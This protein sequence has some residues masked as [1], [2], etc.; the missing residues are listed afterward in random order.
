MAQ[1]TALMSPTLG[2][3]ARTVAIAPIGDKGPPEILDSAAIIA[4]RTLQ[5]AD[6]FE[7]M[8]AMI[9]RHLA[10][11]V[12]EQTGD[13]AATA[14]ILANALVRAAQPC[15]AAGSN[16]VAL[17]RGMERGLEIACAELRR[18]ARMIELPSEIASVAA[19]AVGDQDVAEMIGEV[20]DAVGADGAIL[21]ENSAGPKTECEYVEGVRWNEGYLSHF[22]LK[23]GESTARL[24]DPRIHATDIALER[25]DQLVPALE[26]CVA[27][28]D[29]SLLVIA[30]EVRDAALGLL[31][32]NRDRGV[33]D[34]VMAVKAPAFGVTQTQILE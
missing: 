27:A 28:G 22:L 9:I 2:P 6:P 17:R 31:I 32:A 34:S 30:P 14:A 5:L 13:G 19:G 12:S 7:D 33:V 11:R 26:A 24:L 21:V 15:L 29:R 16:P 20:V 25:A 1:M 23:P 3:I 18:Q 4:R 8:G 10:L